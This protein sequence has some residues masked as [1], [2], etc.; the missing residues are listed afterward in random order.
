MIHIQ[1]FEGLFDKILPE[2]V[3]LTDDNSQKFV[4]INFSAVI[5]VHRLE[6]T[7]DIDFFNLNLVVVDGLDE[8]VHVEGA[9]TVVV[10]DLELS[11]QADNS[12]TSA[13]S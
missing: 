10:E 7:L 5:E 3:H 1:R 8:L 12:P 9:R 4:K 11:C 6:K 13:I 2:L